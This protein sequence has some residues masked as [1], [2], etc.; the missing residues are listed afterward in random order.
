MRRENIPNVVRPVRQ[1]PF[2]RVMVGVGVVDSVTLDCPPPDVEE[3]VLTLGVRARPIHRLDEERSRIL[4]RA[5][6]A[7]DDD[8]P[9]PIMW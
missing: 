5:D 3:R 1:E 2:D 7:R 6:Q 9:K 8:R 4:S